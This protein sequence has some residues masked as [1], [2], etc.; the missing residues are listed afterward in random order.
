MPSPT[1]AEA[2]TAPGPSRSGGRRE[3]CPGSRNWSTAPSS[4]AARGIPNTAHDCLGSARACEPPR[5][6]IASRPRAAVVAH[7][8]EDH[9]DRIRP[10]PARPPNGTAR[11]RDGLCTVCAVRGQLEAQARARGACAAPPGAMI[12]VTGPDGSG[13]LRPTT[14]GNA[15]TRFIHADEPVGEV[16]VEVLHD[17][18]RRGEVRR[19]RPARSAAGAGPAAAGRGDRHDASAPAADP[20]AARRAGSPADD[21]SPGTRLRLRTVRRSSAS[22]LGCQRA[23]SAARRAH[24][25]HERIDGARR[26]VVLHG[27]GRGRGSR[28]GCC[29]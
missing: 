9:A 29:A 5:A 22:S 21:G 19:G 7:A 25:P 27:G 20:A 26:P 4:P 13:R 11:R 15:D 24:L 23:A 8:G 3:R 10:T 17:Q 14:T 6:E 18:D 1:R 2:V 16:R 28:R 12:D